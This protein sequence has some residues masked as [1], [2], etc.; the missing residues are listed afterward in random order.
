MLAESVAMRYVW[1]LVVLA[2]YTMRAASMPSL[3]GMPLSRIQKVASLPIILRIG[4]GKGYATNGAQPRLPLL[5]PLKFRTMDDG[6]TG[7]SK[8][9]HRAFG[10]CGPAEFRLRYFYHGL[11]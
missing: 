2:A 9:L 1:E 3:F 5:S 11:G 10:E 6:S 4:Q 8:K 7:S